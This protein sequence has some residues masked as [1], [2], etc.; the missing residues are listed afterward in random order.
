MSVGENG[1]FLSPQRR[2]PAAVH[3]LF[4]SGFAPQ[5]L[6][7]MRGTKTAVEMAQDFQFRAHRF[8]AGR[9]VARRELVACHN[10]VGAAGS[11]W[12]SEV[13][14]KNYLTSDGEIQA[15]HPHLPAQPMSRR[16]DDGVRAMSLRKSDRGLIAAG[17]R[18]PAFGIIGS[19][20]CDGRSAAAKTRLRAGRG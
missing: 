13:L 11:P 20:I 7:R 2:E 16:A 12:H 17:P 10:G 14:A 18:R 6:Y 8:L 5:P 4:M 15:V 3:A 9:N 1:R 19:R